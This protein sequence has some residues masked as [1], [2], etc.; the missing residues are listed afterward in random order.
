MSVPDFQIY[1]LDI[2]PTKGSYFLKILFCKRGLNCIFFR[3]N[4]FFK[5]KFPVDV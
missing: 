5:R 3:E 1:R 4:Y 2:P